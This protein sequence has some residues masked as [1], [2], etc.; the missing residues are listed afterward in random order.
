M[1]IRVGE[2]KE[3]IEEGE[4]CPRRTEQRQGGAER[5]CSPY[6]GREVCKNEELNPPSL[7]QQ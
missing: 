2:E 4:V 6:T 7:G 5:Q 3:P 1:S